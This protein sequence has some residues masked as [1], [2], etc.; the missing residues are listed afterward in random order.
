MAV[1]RVD[2]ALPPGD[3]S[4]V[5][6]SGQG[7]QKL[8]PNLP[9]EADIH[10]LILDKNQIIKLENLEK[11]RRLIQLSVANNRLVRM[12]GVAKLTQL[13]VLNLP[14]NSIGYVEGLKELVHLEWLNLA[15]NNLKAMEQ[16]NSCAALQHLDLSDNSIPQIGDLSKLLSL[17]TLL[18]HG[19]I[20]TSLRMAPAYLPRSLAILSLAENEVRDLNEI[21]F[22]ASLTEL[23]QLSIM[24]NPCV[25][26]TPS[27]PGFDYRPYIVSWCLNL[28]VLDGYVISQKESLKAE[29]LYSQGKGRAYRPGQHIQ[30]VQ[31]LATVCPLT[32]TLGLQTAEDAKLEKILSKQRF[33]Q[34][35]LMNQSQNEELSPL[36]PVE[37]RAPLVPEHS[38]P[39][40]DCQ[41][42]QESEPVIQV[43]SWVGIS[44]DDDQLYGVKNNFPAS[45]HT[46]RYSRNDLRLEDIQ[47]DEDKLSCSLLS[48]ESTFMP[49]A[50]G[51]SPVSPT[52]ELRLQGIN[53][54]LEDDGVAD[55]SVKGLGN[56]DFDKEEE[57][58]FWAAKENSV[59]AMK[60]P[61]ST[62]VN[63][64]DGPLPCPEPT[65]TSAV[66]KD[67][68]HSLTSSPESVGHNV[69]HT[70]PDGEEI[71]SQ[72]A[73]EKLPCR[74]LTQRCV[75]LGQD[76][77]ALQ[78]LNEAATKLQA[79]WRGFYA[80]NY[81]PQAKDVRY[82][83]RLRRMQEHIV[84]LTDEIRRLRKERD[85]ERIKKFVQEEAVRFLWNQV[86]SLQAWQQ[87]V[88][89]RLSSWRSDV[90]P[91]SSTL[92]PSKPPSFTQSQ[93]SSSDHNSDWFI[94]P[95]EAPQEKSLREFP[96]SG[97]HS[98]LTEQIHCL[99]DSLD[100]EK[101]STEDSESSIMGN[102]VD[103]VKYGKES[104]VGD[105]SEEHGEWSKES[106]NDEQDK[107]LLEQYLT[108]VQQLEDADERTN[109]DEGTG[110]SKL[111]IACSP[112]KLDV[113]S[114]IASVDDAHGLSPALQAEI[115]QTPENCKLNAEVQG[116]QSECEST[117]H[118]LHVGVIV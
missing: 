37:T 92:V 31:Y 107:S 64:K 41:I 95:D 55:E 108:S 47:T 84:C 32:S 43:N 96:D 88:D 68:T 22:L 34:R 20:I 82:E 19:N 57:K 103:T 114:D 8:S 1:A 45:V 86:R 39:V 27:I 79:C 56:Q 54:G 21:S 111:Y 85:E 2:A 70:Q 30:L 105:V 94:A 28:R 35:Q 106:S 102:S 13:R 63:E 7:L 87:M 46:A 62:E 80:R 115:S 6:W 59:Q 76:K 66:L 90:P 14:H 78:K 91:L 73:S 48:S 112:E 77:V 117:F 16:I 52:V 69:F 110:D 61:I 71:M 9:C 51:L 44:S 101:S 4:V 75:A 89:Q 93:E 109:F 74:V 81:N 104:D 18:L 25:M 97:F 29:W 42:V 12:M 23:E 26:A 98:S 53:L 49:V 24:N 113:L 36:A 116:Q 58:A 60:S 67:D 5:N 72:T 40:Q 38:S 15:G 65:V 99:Q 3:G 17:K 11:C 118:V 33:H 83:I 10:T 50:S 100:F